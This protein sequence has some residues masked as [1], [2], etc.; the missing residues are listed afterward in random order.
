MKLSRTFALL[1]AAQALSLG[2]LAGNGQPQGNCNTTYTLDADFD[3]GVLF[4][5]NHDAPNS[6]QLQ[7]NTTTAP[8]PFVNI[9][10]SARGT[11]VR[12]DVNTD[13]ILGEYYTAPNGMGRNPSRT[14]VDRLGNVWVSNRDEGGSV[15]GVAHGSIARVAIVIGGTRGDKDPNTGAFTPNPAGQY[16]TLTLDVRPADCPNGVTV[17]APGL[18]RVDGVGRPIALASVTRALQD[19]TR[20]YYGASGGCSTA[21]PEGYTDLVLNVPH[22]MLVRGLG[23]GSLPTGTEVEV[24]LSGS[25]TDGTPFAVRD[26]LR[27]Q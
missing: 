13:A 27:V 22:W 23:L 26:V 25:L 9:A 8:L 18:A 2:A 24:E 5:V 21:G 15:G 10:C 14:T 20:P 4:N 3:L 6:D 17:H 16:G 7:L 11:I 19:V 1:A 12:I